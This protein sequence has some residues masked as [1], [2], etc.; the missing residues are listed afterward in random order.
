MPSVP[1]PLA[2][3]RLQFHR[4]FRFEDARALVPYLE[5]LGVT[6]LYAS[7]ILQ[8][9]KG[10]SHGYDV[11]DSTRLN[12]E[13]GKRGEFD[14]LTGALKDRGMGLV[15]DI[16]PNHMSAS[17]ENRWWMDVL[18]NGAGSPFA[19]YFDIDWHSPKKALEKKV[20]L[21]VLGGPY[22]RVLENQEL[23]LRLEKGG[24]FVHYH[25]LKLPLALKSYA[26]ILAHRLEVLEG[27]FGPDH[28][29]FRELWGLIAD[30]EHLP[31]PSSADPARAGE[32]FRAGESIRKRLYRMYQGRAEVRAHIDET[33][34]I[35]RGA[36]G[37]AASFDFLD[38]LLAEQPYWLSFWRLANEE[39]NYRRFFAISDLVSLRVEDPFVFDATHDFVLRLAKEGSVTGLRV[40][41]ID[42]LYDPM[43]YLA[44]IRN[45][46]AP[47]GGGGPRDGFFV[48]V[49]KILAEGE[50]LPADWPVSGTTGYDFLNA[51]TGVFA[52]AAGTRALGET[53]DRFLGGAQE[54]GEMVYEKKKLVMDTLFA[55]E[56]HSLG[57]HL[58]GLAEQDRYA[59]D[60]PRKELRQALIEVTASFSVYRTYIRGFDISARDRRY[61]GKALK[62]A[63]HRGTEASAPVFDFL[64]RVLLLESPAF[65]AEGQRQEWLRFL[66]RW[67]QFTGPIMAKGYEDTALY[68]FNR[69]TSLN[70]VGGEPAGFGVSVNAFHKRAG[71]TAARWPQTM[72]AT[73][74]HDT[75]RSEDIRARINVLSEV[76]EEWAKRLLHWSD[77]NRAL[78]RT[79]GDR[80]VPDPGEE[81]LLYQ[82][83]LGAWPLE[84]GEMDSFPERV[85]DYM[86]KA[87]R[88]AK[89]H[90]RW[91]RPNPEY[92]RAVRDFVTALL[93]DGEG[94]PFREDFLPF[95]AKVAHYGAQNGLAQ[96]TLKIASPGVPDFY[97]GAE[98]WDLRL[99]DPDNRGPVDFPLRIRLLAE[100]KE[101][102]RRGL[103]PL[104]GEL[105]PAWQDGRIKLFVTYRALNFRRERRDLFLS[106][107]YLPL[108]AS[109][110][111]KEHVLAFARRYKAHWAVAA[112]PRLVTRLSPP[113][114]FPLGQEA[115]GSRSGLLL[116]EGA[117]DR[118]RNA[119]TGEEIRVSPGR[120]KKT[121][122]LHAVFRHLPVALLS[123]IAE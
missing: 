35:Y 54:F 70:E 37:D 28:P 3:Y 29:S 19:S 23:S 12:P 38:R 33:L 22:G 46:L 40:D 62:E 98:L 59:R 50:D 44:R 30:I 1:A 96:L 55:G 21:P 73:G 106:G 81:I 25:G 87:V 116:P 15:L 123:N 86:V 41:H 39:I 6:D 105:L 113:G 102:E 77:G 120:G 31:D 17:S 78:K 75:K 57:Q 60:L 74:T 53:Y 76:P 72:N 52:S 79:V 114:A 121:L 26:R 27:N 84:P 64:R 119:I 66:M 34:R 103:I 92:E 47:A 49:E 24:F 42:G 109:G 104:V 94:A 5:T 83:L 95:Q 108:S 65:A 69:L 58:A 4:R 117:P 68:V 14:A 88:E 13:L 93:V 90:T 18:E 100:L 45:R 11:T 63:M 91:I 118:W 61:L 10:S 9:R 48:L 89:V 110:G 97:Q 122:P 20:L 80:P 16:V 2:T 111:N 7:P 85:R 112:V 32:R 99:V 71:E 51:A 56:M 8:A 107:A 36:K 115:W 82:T 101:R 43:S 67:Q